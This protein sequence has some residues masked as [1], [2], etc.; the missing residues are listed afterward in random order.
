MRWLVL[1]LNLEQLDVN[2]VG[3]FG[4]PRTTDDSGTDDLRNVALDRLVAPL[5]CG[6]AA[7]MLAL[8]K[9]N[10]ERKRWIQTLPTPKNHRACGSE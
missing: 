2:V 8:V 4:D 7:D 10:E 5:L 6:T 3:E 1:D 9:N